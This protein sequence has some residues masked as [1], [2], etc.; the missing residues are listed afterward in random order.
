MTRLAIF[1]VGGVIL[2]ALFGE[3]HPDFI[4]NPPQSAREACDQLADQ[5]DCRAALA[6][7]DL[8]QKRLPKA[9]PAPL[10]PDQR[11]T[12]GAYDPTITQEN[13]AATICNPKFVAA[14][15]P[16]PSWTAAATRRI[17]AVQLPDIDPGSLVLDQLVPISLGGAPKDYRNLW[18]QS[19]AG[20]ENAEK[21]D[22][23]E[24]LL[25]RMVCSGQLTLAAAQEAVAVNWLDT[26]RRAMTMQNL[27]RYTLPANWAISS[28][29]LQ[30]DFVPEPQSD[31]GPVVLEAQI[32]PESQPYEVPAIPVDGRD[33]QSM[34]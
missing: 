17:A 25:N 2:A 22:G 23:L 14:R 8:R 10:L 30:P 19:W 21:K 1:A 18:L 11:R 29:N 13:I 24:T 27:A 16:P 34:E 5:S 6:L 9:A 12:P 20:K 7:N 26:Y 32:E 31:S 28:P 15:K 4:E 3:T 33:F